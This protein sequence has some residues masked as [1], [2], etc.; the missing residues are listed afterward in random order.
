VF[1]PAKGGKTFSTTDLLMHAAHG[2]DWHECKVTRP[3]NVA[4]L[5][6]EGRNGLRIRLHAWLEHHDTAHLAGAFKILP[7]ALSLPERVDEVIAL[8]APLAPDV[9]A[10]DT[11]NA[12][13]GAG[14]ENSTQDMTLFVAACRRLRDQ[15]RCS[16]LV[17]HHTPLVDNGR[18]RGSGV[19]RAAADVVIQVGRDEGDSGC[20]GFQVVTGRDIEAMPYPIALRLEPV[21]TDWVDE[22]NEPVTTCVVKG[23]SEPVTLAGHGRKLGEAQATVLACA[24]ELAD[25]RPIENGWVML[26]RLDVATK[27]KDQGVTKQSLRAAWKSLQ[28][29]GFFKLVE[30]GSVKLRVK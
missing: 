26:A 8:L 28:A 3:L 24:R 2:L 13:F 27:A 20:I 10:A 15:L 9:V 4:F 14:D 17:L 11:L 18:E 25:G 29:R 19:L 23:A 30:P 1:G 21:E 6:G 7:A 12:Y 5:A 16:V 22:D